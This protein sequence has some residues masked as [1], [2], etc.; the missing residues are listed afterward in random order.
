MTLDLTTAVPSPGQLSLARSQHAL[1]VQRLQEQMGQLVPQG[2]VAELQ[3]LLDG[4]RQAAR[5]LREEEGRRLETQR[6]SEDRP[7]AN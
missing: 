3:R 4:E 1:E 2:R 7:R 5:R 6:V